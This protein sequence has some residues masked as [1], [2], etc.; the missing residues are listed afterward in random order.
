MSENM[1]KFLGLLS[2]NEELAQKLNDADKDTIIAMAKELG[3]ELTE[4]DFAQPGE[5][6]DD[7]LDAVAGG[8]KCA[9]FFGGGGDAYGDQLT[10]VCV[11]GGGGEIWVN[12]KKEARC[13]CVA[14]GVGGNIS[15][16][17]QDL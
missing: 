6:S 12:G 3:F 16:K 7:E 4:V 17:D 5:L 13:A 14:G 1:K 8:G 15:F 9:C 2:E 10:C 11:A